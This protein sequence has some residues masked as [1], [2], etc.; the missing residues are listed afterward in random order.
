MTAGGAANWAK[1]PVP[2]IEPEYLTGILAAACDLAF[3]VSSDGI[4]RSLLID[5]DTQE[6]MR[7]SHWAG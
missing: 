4:V 3:V 2:V 1:G 7:I 6:H 5:E